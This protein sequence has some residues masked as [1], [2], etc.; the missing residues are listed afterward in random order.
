MDIETIRR[1][2]LAAWGEGKRGWRAA[3]A[4]FRPRRREG[5][6]AALITA[7][8]VAAGFGADRYVEARTVTLYRVLVDGEDVG[9]ASSPD[10]VDAWIQSRL[11]QASARADGARAVVANALQ[12]RAERVYRGQADDAGVLAALGERLAVKVEAVRLVVDG[13]TIG[14]VKNRAAAEAIVGRVAAKV[15]REPLVYDGKAKTVKIARLSAP[16]PKP[17]AETVVDAALK[18]DVEIVPALVDPEAV[19]DETDVEARLMGEDGEAKV[20]IQPGDTLSGIAARYNMKLDDLLA[21][22]PGL[23]PETILQIGQE[24]LVRRA[25]PEIVVQTETTKTVRVPVPYT[26]RT[27]ED[28]SLYKGERRVQQPGK[29]GVKEVTYRLTRENGDVVEETVVDERVITPPVEA[30]IVV[31][32]KPRPSAP[33]GQF[34]WPTRGGYITS[35][36]GWRGGKFHPAVD[37]SGV[38]DRTIVAAAAGTVTFAGW[39]GGY[40]HLVK[41]R[42][43]GGYETWYA[44]LAR[45]DVSAGQSVGQGQPIGAMGATGHATGVHL[46][47]E[48]H[49]NGQAQD[50]TKYVGRR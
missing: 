20:V 34:L 48:I 21:L 35:G 28:A 37:I 18:N 26:T 38:A 17:E 9:A 30:V 44:H 22:N 42:H 33:A 25:K 40:G 47:F 50:P 36:Y 4:F 7:A 19:D 23:T 27:I 24:I 32:T 45:I 12:F 46:H 2:L 29:D 11:R 16:A 8:L 49:H 14:V 43:A 6:L 31:G 39:D 15:A 13:K 1:R 5:A 10:V 41:I 3:V